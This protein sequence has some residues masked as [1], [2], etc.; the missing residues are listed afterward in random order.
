MRH[1]K[2]IASNLRHKNAKKFIMESRHR[3]RPVSRVWAC[4]FSFFIPAVVWT[5]KMKKTRKW[6]VLFSLLILIQIGDVMLYPEDDYLYSNLQ[7]TQY[8]NPHIEGLMQDIIP[9][10]A[11][12]P[13]SITFTV[14][15]DFVIWIGVIF[16]MVY[17]MFK[18]TTRYNLENFGHKSKREW[19]QSNPTEK[20]IEE[21]ISRAGKKTATNI[22]YIGIKTADKIPAEKIREAGASVA[23]K[24]TDVTEKVTDVA[25]TSRRSNHDQAIK[26][27][28]K[29]HNLMLRNIISESDFERKKSQLLGL[30]DGK[31]A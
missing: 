13:I 14:L 29:Y 30:D 8:P 5:N 20:N 21:S 10:A 25:K 28:E 7:F 6:M 1:D 26:E 23:E 31:S 16:A 11:V 3:E 24:V 22:K 18:W 17:Y 15:W 12:Y 4:V 27:I 19:K 2:R 9:D